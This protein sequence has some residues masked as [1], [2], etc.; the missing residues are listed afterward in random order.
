MKNP[1]TALK[2]NN[3]NFR[4]RVIIFAAVSVGVIAT[5]VVLSKMK[6]SAA[7]G[8]LYEVLDQSADGV[9]TLA[10]SE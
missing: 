9:L 2:E 7:A 8:E 5:A 10:P 1:I 4:K 3:N 6:D